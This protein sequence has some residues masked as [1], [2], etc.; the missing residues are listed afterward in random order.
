MGTNHDLTTEHFHPRLRLHYLRT[1]HT[2]Y[3]LFILGDEKASQSSSFIYL[4]SKWAAEGTT[5]NSETTSNI[6]DQG[7][8]GGRGFK[9][10]YDNPSQR[11]RYHRKCGTVNFGGLLYDF[12]GWIGGGSRYSASGL[13]FEFGADFW[14]LFARSVECSVRLAIHPRKSC[15]VLL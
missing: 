14:S 9:Q 10:N 1:L 7:G 6:P 3:L 8:G 11:L 2:L 4:S 13:L 15:L 5:I 12:Y